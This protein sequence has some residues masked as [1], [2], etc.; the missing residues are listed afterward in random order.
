MTTKLQKQVILIK[1][2]LM[3][4]ARQELAARSDQSY[5][6]EILSGYWDQGAGMREVL[7]D[8]R[9]VGEHK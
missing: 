9:L 3:R 5:K 1:K 6:R 2:S 7:S 8:L 4:R